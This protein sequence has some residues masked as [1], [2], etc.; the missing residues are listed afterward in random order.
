[1]VSVGVDERGLVAGCAAVAGG[2]LRAG[3]PLDG[4]QGDIEAAGAFE[5]AD[6]LAEQM[7]DPLPALAGGL[8][9]YPPGPGG[10]HSGG[11]AGG[12]G[13]DLG[14]DLAAQVA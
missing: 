7:V 8:L 11:P 10:V 12:V 14:Q 3:V 4:V 1:V 13:A 6:V 9:A 2:L 5:Q